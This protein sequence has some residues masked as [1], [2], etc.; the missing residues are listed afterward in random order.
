[1]VVEQI[2]RTQSGVVIWARVKAQNGI[3]PS[4]T[5]RSGRVHSRYDRKL[6]DGSVA[7]QSVMLRLRVRRFFCDGPDCPVGTFAEQIEGLTVK[8]ARRTSL[9]RKALEHIGLALVGRAGSRLATRLGLLASRSTLLRLMYALPDPDVGTVAVLGVDDVALR[10]GRKYATVL[11]DAVTHRRV[12]VLPDR[13]ADTLAA[14][15]REHP[16]VRMVCRDG[17]AAY[18]DAIRQGAPRA[19]QISD[20]WHLW[21]NLAKAVEK[22]VTAHSHC[23]HTGPP[24]TTTSPREQR[25][26]QRY[27]AVHD[28]LAQGVGLLECARRLG[29]ALNTVKRYA[30]AESAEALQ[31]PP[32]YRRTLVDPYRDHLRR[33]ADEPGVPVTRLL[34][35]HQRRHLDELITSCPQ[36]TALVA[37]VR[38]FAALLTQRRGADLDEWITTVRADD[39]PALHAFTH[40]L[41]MD[42]DAVVAGLTLPYSNGPAEGVNTK[43][44]YLKRQMFGRAGFSLLRKRILLS[45]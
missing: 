42:H 40:G 27:A 11:I 32:Q 2:E 17:S 31:R 24:R 25:T 33:L 41:E 16:G 29:W 34:P 43:V 26:R 3:C 6:A 35:D 13:K 15:L 8:H 10:R 37:R 22:T 28:L 19:V 7:G 38:E 5:G 9:C 20:R 23:W 18:A 4:C 14:W 45:Q 39:L 1:M 12:D 30:R 21:H 36:M 44:K